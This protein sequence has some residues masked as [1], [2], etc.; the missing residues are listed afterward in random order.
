MHVATSADIE[1]IDA[2]AAGDVQYLAGG[3]GAG[4]V[5]ELADGGLLMPLEGT[6][7]PA[8]YESGGGISRETSRC[9]VLRSD[10]GG[11]NWEHWA[12]VAFDP[13]QI[14]S[15]QE[16]TMARLDDGRLITMMFTSFRHYT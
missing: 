10:D 9:F 14:I 8:G 3:T 7:D 11:N 1:V 16:P 12:T 15:F 5:V 2:T 4:H 13:A 6:L